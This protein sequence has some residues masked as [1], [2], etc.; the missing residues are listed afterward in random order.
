M[1][2][3][4]LAAHYKPS[5]CVLPAQALPT[6]PGASSA[7]HDPDDLASS[8]KKFEKLAPS[9]KPT[10]PPLARL[11][12]EGVSQATLAPQTHSPVTQERFGVPACAW[13]HLSA[14]RQAQTGGGLTPLSLCA[15]LNSCFAR[16]SPQSQSA[17][18]LRRTAC[19]AR[20]IPT[21]RFAVWSARWRSSHARF[22]RC[23]SE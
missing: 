18:W 16:A 21:V 8:V 3:A 23:T 13:P 15:N 19:R 5:K 11:A 12:G 10:G 2:S 1:S 4:Q 14:D 6:E 22:A 7:P 17:I 9:G 20:G